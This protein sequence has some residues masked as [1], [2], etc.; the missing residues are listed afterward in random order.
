MA[1]TSVNDLT[2]HL[3][4]GWKLRTA[5]KSWSSRIEAAR[6]RGSSPSAASRPKTSGRIRRIAAGV[7]R[8]LWRRLSS[9]FWNMPRPRV[10]GN[11]TAEAVLTERAEGW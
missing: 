11:E 4:H 1:F 8:A 9:D 2:A 10:P 5:V 3:A 6:W 7:L